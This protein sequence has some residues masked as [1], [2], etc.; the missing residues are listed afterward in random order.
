MTPKMWTI[1]RI[2]NAT[3]EFLRDKAIGSPRLCAEVLLAHQLKKT[4][5]QLYL[6]FDRPLKSDEISGF[7]SLVRRRLRRE[8]LQYITGHQEFW[9][10]DFIVNSEVLIPRPETERLIEEAVV[11]KESDFFSGR[12]QLLHLMT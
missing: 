3:T 2:L 9:S 1:Q 4:R 6:E 7:R 12:D 10:L 5:V 8:P 11:L